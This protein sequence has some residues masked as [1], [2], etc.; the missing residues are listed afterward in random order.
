MLP[1]GFSKRTMENM[2]ELDML[3]MHNKRY[4]VEVAH[5]I[6]AS[7]RKEMVQGCDQLG[8]RMVNRYARM[9]IEEQE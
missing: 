6:G 1:S 7:K 9:P 5:G 3:M 2:A 4:A 8:L